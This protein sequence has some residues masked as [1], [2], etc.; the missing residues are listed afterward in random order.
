MLRASDDVELL[1]A[2]AP[3]ITTRVT[4]RRTH[5]TKVPMNLAPKKKLLRTEHAFA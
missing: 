5:A 1:V 3:G 4:A 2:P